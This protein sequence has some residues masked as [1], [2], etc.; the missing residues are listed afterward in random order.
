M[1]LCAFNALEFSNQ[2]EAVN[3]LGT[4]LDNYIYDGEP[5]NFYAID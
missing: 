3:Q 2:M 4:F 5:C 1:R